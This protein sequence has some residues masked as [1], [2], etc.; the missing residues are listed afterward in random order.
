M[1][2]G[3]ILS[4]GKK[5]RDDSC[6]LFLFYSPFF[7]SCPRPLSQL[8]GQDNLNLYNEILKRSE[9]VALGR[10]ERPGGKA[11]LDELITTIPSPLPYDF[12]TRMKQF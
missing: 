2:R 12:L 1:T 7:L 11:R 3:L 4:R 8:D 9:I 5:K 6:I 10:S